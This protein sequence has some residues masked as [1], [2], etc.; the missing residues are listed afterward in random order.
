MH[1]RAF[2]DDHWGVEEALDE[3][4]QDSRG[5]ISRGRHWLILNSPVATA[6][7]THRPLAFELLHNPILGFSRFTSIPEYKANF[8]S[9]VKFFKF[10]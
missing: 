3:P 8:L 1:R 7:R 2:W 10:N 6:A 9:S 5:L 4:G